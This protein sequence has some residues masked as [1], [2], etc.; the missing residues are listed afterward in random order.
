MTY[1]CRSADRGEEAMKGRP[2]MLHHDTTARKGIYTKLSGLTWNP[3]AACADSLYSQFSLDPPPHLGHMAEYQK[4]GSYGDTSNPCSEFEPDF[5][6]GDGSG[7]LLSYNNA[8]G[9]STWGTN[10]YEMN[11]W[12]GERRFD[13]NTGKVIMSA[14]HD[15][16]STDHP[17]DQSPSQAVLNNPR[18]IPSTGW[19][20]SLRLLP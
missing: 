16:R 11:D 1:P 13:W 8:L 5:W 4:P 3:A 10:E 7:M 12:M 19:I 9:A 20:L 6:S 17:G 2:F 14:S 15:T 18:Q